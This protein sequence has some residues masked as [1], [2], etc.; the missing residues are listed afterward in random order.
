MTMYLIFS[1]NITA[2][3]EKMKEEAARGIHARNDKSIIILHSVMIWVMT[4][5]SL[6][7]WT[8]T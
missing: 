8:T 7:K 3:N 4:P 1:S 2:G 6:V 5:H